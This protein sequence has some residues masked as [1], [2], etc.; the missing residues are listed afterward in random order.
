MA[1]YTLERIADCAKYAHKNYRLTR[2]I[3]W[4]VQC[5][6]CLALAKDLLPRGEFTQWLIRHGPVGPTQC[7]RYVA[8]FL[9]WKMIVAKQKEERKR[10]SRE[11]N[12]L[13]CDLFGDFIP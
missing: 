13:F 9:G 8:L 4:V 1:K 5:G 10:E 11:F 7:R 3:E 12:K 6:G 2:N